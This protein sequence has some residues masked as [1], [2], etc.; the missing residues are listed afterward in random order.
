[1][2]RRSL[3][4]RNNSGS[5][6]SWLMRQSN[7]SRRPWCP[8]GREFTFTWSATTFLPRESSFTRK[9]YT[10]TERANRSVSVHFISVWSFSPLF[11]LPN[12]FDMVPKAHN[13]ADMKPALIQPRMSQFKTSSEKVFGTER[14]SWSPIVCRAWWTLTECLCLTRTVWSKLGRP[15][16]SWT[17]KARLSGHFIIR[18]E[19]KPRSERLEL[20]VKLIS[21]STSWTLKAWKTIEISTSGA[22]HI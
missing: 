9:Q 12:P 8:F 22:K 6:T 15:R 3:R 16:T 20:G 17:T 5:E 13:Q 1:M 14:S 4:S 21:R 11:H 7:V 10:D 18:V 2:G 19:V